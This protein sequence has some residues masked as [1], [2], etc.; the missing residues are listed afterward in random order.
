MFTM[1]CVV[2]TIIELPLYV[3]FQLES[4]GTT[5]IVDMFIDIVFWSDGVS[6]CS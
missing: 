6:V 4:S 2:L 5:K 1:V 3:G